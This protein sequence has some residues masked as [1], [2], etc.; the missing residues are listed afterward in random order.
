GS[1]PYR[2]FGS[3]L[4]LPFRPFSFPCRVFFGGLLF[5]GRTSKEGVATE[6][7]KSRKTGSEH[8]IRE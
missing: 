7:E 1:H 5:S 2:W 3:N 8:R 4:F 6:K